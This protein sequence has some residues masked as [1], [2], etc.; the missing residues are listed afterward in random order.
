MRL[1]VIGGGG[2]EHAICWSLRRENPEAQLYCAPGNPGTEGIAQ[3]LTIAADDLDRLAD[4][5]DMHGIDL[6]IIGPE[7]PLARGLADRLRAEGRLVLGPSAAAAQLEASK[8]FAKEVMQAAGVPTAASRT[9]TDIPAALEYIER[10]QEPLVV[11][12]S[13][14]AGGKGAVVCAT[15]SEARSAVRAMI[16]AFLEGEELSVL[17]L[18]NGRE[19]ELLP[20]AQDHKRLL[21]GDIGPNTGGMGAYSPVALATPDLLER[22]K[23]EVLEPT[24][25]QMQRQG[26]PFSGVLYAGLMI[27]SDGAPWV[28]EFNC[29]LG[30]P[31]AQVVLP[32]ISSG[33]TDAFLNVAQ[34]NP[35]GTLSISGSAAVTTV[36]ASRGYPDAPEKGAAIMLP[37]RQP[38]GVIVFHAG[39]TRGADGILRAGGGRVLTTT[40]VATSFTEAQRLSRE[41]AEAVRFDGKIFRRDIGWREAARLYERSA[42]VTG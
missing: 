40:A 13:G 14:L 33:L 3:N 41:A 10:H 5:A 24:L 12:A 23:G 28:V 17:A 20:V 11:K 9:F 8:A 29:R 34:G 22:V 7:I 27:D 39:T 35:P 18:T 30:D 2:R 4:A 6:T 15:R 19:V 26:T 37:E 36:L 1:L 21:E 31:E 16:E 25:E 38:D 32:L 42:A